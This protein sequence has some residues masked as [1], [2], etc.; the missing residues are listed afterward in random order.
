MKR[1]LTVTRRFASKERP[2]STTFDEHIAALRE[3]GFR[4]VATVWQSGTDRALLAVR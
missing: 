1:I 4:E 3:A 2:S